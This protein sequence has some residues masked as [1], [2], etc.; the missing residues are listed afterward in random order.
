MLANSNNA[1]NLGFRCL[2]T[3]ENECNA[4]FG[5]TIHIQLYRTNKEEEGKKRGMNAAEFKRFLS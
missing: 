4:E 2:A 5:V 3:A 1:N